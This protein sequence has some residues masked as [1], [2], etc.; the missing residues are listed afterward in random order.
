M[1]S[2]AA[3]V[4]LAALTAA[5]WLGLGSALL[6]PVAWKGDRVLGLLNRL[7]V[8][9]V[10]F[11]V[12]TFA[13]GLVGGLHTSVFV[14][15]FVVG[16]ALGIVV[17]ARELRTFDVPRL[18]TWSWW[19]LALTVLVA[20][21][22]VL[23]L[24]ITCAPVSSADALYHHAAA[25]ELYARTHEFGE[26]PWAWNS[27]QPYTVE[28]L[29]LDGIL[30]NDLE[31]GAFAP[32]LLGFGALAATAGAAYRLFGRRAAVLAAAIF[33]AQP[34]TAW[35]ATSTFVEPATTLFVA[36]AVWN[37]VEFT[38]SR[39]SAMLLLAGVFA[40][41]AAGTKYYGAAAAVVVAV[42]GAVALRDRLTAR[43]VAPAVGAA[44]VVAAPWYVKNA[45]L[46]G[47]PL[48]PFLRG[49]AN[50]AAHQTVLDSADNYGH[51]T[52]PI[53]LAVLP[54][55]LLGDAQAFDRGEFMS[56]LPLLFAPVA[57]LVP[58]G[59]RAIALALVGCAAFVVMWF[60]GV[61][62]ARYLLPT[63]PVL[64]VLAAVGILTLAST[65]RL[66][67]W[68]TAAVCAGA[69]ASAAAIT[70]VYSAQFVPVVL[71]RESRDTFLRQNTPYY[72]GLEWLNARAPTAGGVALD[73]ILVLYADAP[74]VAWTA[75]AL[76]PGS[77]PA[78]LRAF[79]R[80]YGLTHAELFAASTG[81]RRL[82]ELIGATEI[83]RVTAHNVE[84]R[85]LSRLGPPETMI[86]YELPQG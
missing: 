52:S 31:Q 36:L 50:E 17:A 63:L 55:R 51:G 23:E 76:P 42:V 84:S 43:I 8:G 54:F 60:Y 37:L 25:P 53:D 6:A 66:A 47:D 65:G 40:G 33:W 4:A 14:P 26:L 19:E 85:T 21:Y 59:R 71:G 61:Q 38:R 24:L 74:A 49:G 9:A 27:Y 70:L 34:F 29:I 77:G 12:L 48:Y 1:L 80:R 82:L 44:L 73:H 46:T 15:A 56:P 3:H 64:A 5:S 16:A 13:L 30:L 78:E 11:A 72:E 68:I 62:H 45:V 75:D 67:R 35:I 83:G 28:M 81:K 10:A 7:G 2:C 79:I 41:A 22:V 20:A 39:S 57:L 32:L 58:K 18:R 69:L 86:V